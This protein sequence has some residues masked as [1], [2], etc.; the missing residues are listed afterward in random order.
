MPVGVER[1]TPFNAA[2]VLYLEAAASS[3]TL[4]YGSIIRE[5]PRA[6]VSGLGLTVTNSNFAGFQYM[7][8]RLG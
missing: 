3:E 1:S 6:P 5:E 7:P 8:I 4:A 2:L